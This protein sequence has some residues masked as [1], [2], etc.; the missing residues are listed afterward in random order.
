MQNDPGLE[1]K[2]AQ[3]VVNDAVSEL[4]RAFEA[5][6]ETNDRKLD[7]IEKRYTAD[8]VTS[9]KLAR[10]DRAI[11]DNRRKLDG[12]VLKSARPGLGGEPDAQSTALSLQRKAQFEGYVRRGEVRAPMEFGRLTEEKAMSVGSAGDGG[13]VVPPETEAAVN[14]SLRDVSPIRGIAD[15]RQVSATVFQKPTVAADAATGWVAET[16]VRTQTT[17]PNLTSLSFPTMELYAMPAATQSLLDDAII[18][19]DQ[20]LGDEVRDAFAQQ[21][22]AAFVNGNGTTKP[23]GF[24]AYDQVADSAWVPGKIG[25]LNTGAVGGFATAAPADRLIDLTYAVRPGYRANGAFVMNRSSLSAVRKLKDST[26]DYFWMPSD[27]PGTPSTL[28]GYPVVESEDMPSIAADATAIA[29]GDFKR[30]YLIVDRVGIRVLRD[31]F[32]AKPYV[33]FYTTKR[34]GGGVQDFA[35]IKLLKFSA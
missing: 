16:A 2:V 31:P 26:G 30:G 9:D 12:L 34:V 13:Y 6:K 33:L 15:V 14:R 22:G 5:F 4:M 1:T 32:S 20:W 19:L 17:T 3:S 27:K 23:K 29:F 18:N 10:I 35:A 25:A 28:M 8:V 7:E 21:E 24:L 11:D